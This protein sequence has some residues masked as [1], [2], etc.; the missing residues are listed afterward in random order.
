M[1]HIQ[2][3]DALRPTACERKY[4]MNYN[5]VCEWWIWNIMMFLWSD[6]PPIQIP[7]SYTVQLEWSPVERKWQALRKR[8]TRSYTGNCIA[9]PSWSG[10]RQNK[11]FLLTEETWKEFVVPLWSIS[12]HRQ[13]TNNASISISLTQK[14]NQNDTDM[15]KRRDERPGYIN[16]LFAS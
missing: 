5:D 4:L 14:Q 16:Y 1:R 9:K 3:R 7:L 6:I 13:A 12:W 2:S 15:I 8:E 10:K 11:E